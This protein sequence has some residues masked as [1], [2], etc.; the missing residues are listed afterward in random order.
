MS[1]VEVVFNAQAELAEGPVWDVAAQVLWYVDIFRGEVHRLDPATGCDEYWS[2]PAP[3]GSLA[4]RACG[5]L[6]LALADGVYGWVPGEA[7]VPITTP[8]TGMNANRFNDGRTDRQGRFWVGSLHKAETE[9]TGR[10]YRLNPSGDCIAVADG[11]LAANGTAFS[12]DGRRGYHACSQQGT[13]WSFAVDPDTGELSDRRPF[14]Q[15]ARKE[16]APD[17]AIVDDDGCYWL[18]QPFGWRI[19]RYDPLGRTDRVVQM[20][21]E[22]PTSL[23]FG[24]RDGRTLFITTARHSLSPEA[25]AIQPLAG[26][27]LAL[28]TGMSGPADTP[29]AG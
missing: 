16:G 17:G 28:D 9:P 15:I 24:G 18:A 11:I 26:A 14:L 6:I 19:V 8:E 3:V 7:P 27:I 12:P 5:G 2:V 25:L 10:L 29:F 22:M 13:V 23:A 1:G 20:P 21:V 4:L